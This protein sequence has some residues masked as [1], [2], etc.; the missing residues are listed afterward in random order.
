MSTLFPAQFSDAQLQDDVKNFVQ[1][2]LNVDYDKLLRAARVAKDVRL[3][4][5]VS[6]ATDPEVGKE[7]PVQLT[8]EEKH[9]LRRER[10]VPLSE[11]GM[12]PI[13]LTVSL[14]AFLQGRSLRPHS[15]LAPRVKTVPKFNLQDMS[16][17]LSTGERCTAVNS[18]SM[19]PR[20]HEVSCQT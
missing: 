16:S 3:Y 15:P 14:A 1:H 5:E 10:D 19:P 17:R 20:E 4:D 18:A 7:L 9:A 6:R 12:W 8:D 2:I 11:R 13:I